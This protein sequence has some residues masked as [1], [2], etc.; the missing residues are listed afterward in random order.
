MIPEKYKQLIEKIIAATRQKKIVWEKT[1]RTD[2][3]KSMIGA[4][5][6][7]TDNW[8]DLNGIEYVDFAIWNSNGV[9]VDSVQ[10]GEGSV[11]YGEI[12]ELY[13]AAKASY[14]KADETIAD[15]LEHLNK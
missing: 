9:K 8:H 1:S 15:I 6:V 12:M 13:S 10:G 2:E 3:F 4:S 14:L 11:E 5:M 7:T